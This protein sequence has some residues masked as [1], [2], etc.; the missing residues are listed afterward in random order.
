MNAS[1]AVLPL[2]ATLLTVAFHPLRAEEK[3]GV[4][5]TVQKKTLDRND[6]R[7]GY[8]SYDRI[9]R[10]QGLK[11]T[12]RNTTFK[13][14]AEGE[15]EWTIIVRRAGYSTS[16]SGFSGVEKLK[17]LRPSDTAEMVMGAAQIT[18]WRD[19]YDAAK[20]KMEYQV[21]VKQ[22]GVETVR[23]QTN[24]AFDALA[25]RSTITKTT[26]IE[27]DAAEPAPRGS[28]LAP[29]R[30]AATPARPA[31]TPSRTLP[32]QPLP[33]QPLPVQPLPV[34]PLP[35]KPLP[36]APPQPASG[37]APFGAPPLNGGTQ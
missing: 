3:N 28:A 14:Q 20:D 11:V 30:P 13:P 15:V 22:G 5:L 19:Y 21:I 27:P 33:V 23:A 6:T 26:P 9:D 2:L 31:A 10:T 12:V 7:S 17:A 35:A 18:G 1:A 36:P 37:D 29:P 25:K 32:P 4:M 16:A 8:Y 34:Q 24:P